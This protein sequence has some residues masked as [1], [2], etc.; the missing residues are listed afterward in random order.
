MSDGA[1]EDAIA[2]IS[3]IWLMIKAIME[4]IVVGRS[5]VGLCSTNGKDGAG[6]RHRQ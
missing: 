5:S 1:L 2:A 6:V 4:S 3:A